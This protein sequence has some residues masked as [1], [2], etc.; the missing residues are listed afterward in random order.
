MNPETQ[1]PVAPAKSKKCL[2]ISIVVIVIIAVIAAVLLT[3]SDEKATE[4]TNATSTAPVATT[5][6]N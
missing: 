6:S 2:I 1:A 4:M 3:G 5:T